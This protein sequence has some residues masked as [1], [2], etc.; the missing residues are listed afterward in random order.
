MPLQ[1]ILQL[2]SP[3]KRQAGW[4][5]A[6]KET[7][8]ALIGQTVRVTL[9]NGNVVE[10]RLTGVDEKRLEV[11]RLVDGGEVAY[12]MAIRLIATFEVWQRG[13]AFES[14]DPES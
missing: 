6:D 10:G 2:A 5:S 4:R 13:S 1:V 8:E 9:E 7:A 12:P 11:V 3:D 14:S